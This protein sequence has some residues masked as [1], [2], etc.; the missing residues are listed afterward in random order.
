MLTHIRAFIAGF[1]STLVFHQGAWQLLYLAGA[2]PHAAWDMTGV[3]PLGVASV[4]S[5]AFWGGLWG[6]AIWLLVRRQAGVKRW[7]LATLW[8]ALLPSLVALFVALP[9]LT[10]EAIVLGI[11]AGY[12]VGVYL[13]DIDRTYLWYNML[14]YTQASDVCIGIIKAFIFGGI[15]AVIG[16]YKGMT[17]GEGAE[18]VGR[19]TTE[20]VVFS[21]IT[22]L[23]TNFFLTLSLSEL[24]HSL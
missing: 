24:L 15:V 20:A 17:C 5:L 23:I 21:S 14:K 18:G 4:L 19:A 3:P 8:G 6:I 7:L 2:V 22:I 10:A 16:C 12:A 1:V 9:L 13:L 11:G